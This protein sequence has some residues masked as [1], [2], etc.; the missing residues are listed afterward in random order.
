M[1]DDNDC[2]DDYDYNYD[3]LEDTLDIDIIKDEVINVFNSYI[4]PLNIISDFIKDR[5]FTLKDY[6]ES[7][8]T[9]SYIWIDMLVTLVADNEITEVNNHINIKFS[10]KYS[11]LEYYNDIRE[12]WQELWHSH[13]DQHVTSKLIKLQSCIRRK[14]EIEKWI[15]NLNEYNFYGCGY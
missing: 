1:N 11:F 4:N 3:Y 12:I 8:S 9:N 14:L 5:K 2:D 10:G 7:N 15:R 13:F 6:N